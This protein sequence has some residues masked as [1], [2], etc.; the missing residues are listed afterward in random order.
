MPTNAVPLKAVPLKAVPLKAG[1][2]TTLPSNAPRSAVPYRHRLGSGLVLLLI[3]GVAVGGCTSAPSE[4]AHP[5]QVHPPTA[6]ACPGVSECI[7]CLATA[8]HPGTGP[9]AASGRV[10][11]R[12]VPIGSTDCGPRRPDVLVWA[13]DEAGAWGLEVRAELTGRVRVDLVQ[14]ASLRFAD[15]TRSWELVLEE[16]AAPVVRSVVGTFPEDGSLVATATAFTPEGEPWLWLDEVSLPPT[17][18]WPVADAAALR[19][20]IT[21]TLPDGRRLVERMTRAEAEHRGL[22]P[23]SSGPT[24][25]GR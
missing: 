7:A 3:V 23:A 2:P 22:T 5:R 1:P 12:G 6:A 8:T 24:E 16:G 19:I 25:D 9:S 10:P 4:S 17:G 14:P 13:L 20:P 18:E 21:F 15:G 11:L